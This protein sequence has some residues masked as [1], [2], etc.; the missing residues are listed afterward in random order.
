MPPM[1]EAPFPPKPKAPFPPTGGQSEIDPEAQKSEQLLDIYDSGRTLHANT[2]WENNLFRNGAQLTEKQIKVYKERRQSP[3][4][5]N[6]LK[7]TIEQKKSLLTSNRPSY[8]VTAVEDS[9]VNTSY[10]LNDCL[11]HVWDISEGSGE[12]K[13]AI[14]DVCIGGLGYMLAYRD[15]R[16]DWGKGDVF[17]VNVPY[18]DVYVDPDT[19]NR[20]FKDAAN[21]LV[22]KRMTKDQFIAFMPVAKNK[23]ESGQISTSASTRYPD[24][25]AT[26]DIENSGRFS[27]DG[28]QLSVTDFTEGI[29][30]YEVIDR[31][32]KIEVSNYRVYDPFTNYEKILNV[33]EHEDWLKS[34]AFI[35]HTFN[36]D[37][38]VTAPKDVA[39][40]QDISQD[41]GNVFHFMP[42][43][44][45]AEVMAG[46][47]HDEAIPG[48]THII[49]PTTMG[50]LVRAE[51]LVSLRIPVNRIHRF[52][53]SGGALL[54]EELMEIDEYPIIPF[55]E[56]F[57]RNPY[58]VSVTTLAK[59]VQEHLNKT[60]SLL[61]AYLANATNV[62][63]I[64]GRDTINK[65]D[66]RIELSKAG[67][68]I[69]EVDYD[70]GGAPVIIAPV[71]IPSSSFAEVND[72]RAEIERLYGI[73]SFGQGD[74]SQAPEVFKMGLLLDEHQGRRIG[75]QLNDFYESLNLLAKV[76][77]QLI[78]K[79][80]T[81]KKTFRLVQPNNLPTKTVELNKP[82][83]DQY[84]NE[85]IGKINDVTMGAHDVKAVSGSTLPSQRWMERQYYL[86]LLRE[87]VGDEEM[88]LRESDVKNV[89]E[90]LARKSQLAQ[91]VKLLQEQ[92]DRIKALEGQGQRADS[93]I[94]N[95]RRTVAVEKTKTQLHQEEAQARSATNLYEQ[96]LNDFLRN[97][98]IQ[99]QA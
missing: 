31:Y 9:D 14:D 47:E 73:Y 61:M 41:I 65:E 43:E 90:I 63:V 39:Q 68:A 72:A 86:E 56:G 98:K 36:N 30:Y 1:P 70:I 38:I 48:S 97:L 99:A 52:V 76:T 69:I 27:P 19:K 74:T 89:D 22:A 23:I 29:D 55:T 78:Q 13:E 80:Y 92:D 3:V 11:S 62:K 16:A 32:T 8:Q 26:T 4:P 67:A 91:A 66:L 51:K 17:L 49:E 42:T 21:I 44:Q 96:R 15:P 33:E 64:I 88:V 57:N 37:S 53:S 60:K 59:P 2:Y 35:V 34:R 10:L 24:G 83:Y 75:S 85:L 18:L 25:E 87:G 71:P 54:H 12:L 94:V 46:V 45:G 40:Y 95:L 20:H 58:P 79:T 7:P 50:A 28:I 82:V 93:E 77:I 6:M 84:S 5:W 81:V